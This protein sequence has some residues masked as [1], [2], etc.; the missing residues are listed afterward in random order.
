[1]HAHHFV[2]CFF[3]LVCLC[4]LLSACGAQ[5]VPTTPKVSQRSTTPPFQR[6]HHRTSA[7]RLGQHT[8]R[9]P[10]PTQG[11]HQNIIYIDNEQDTTTV[12]PGV[13]SLKRYDVTTHRQSDIIKLAGDYINEALVSSDGQWLLFVSD[14]GRSPVFKQNCNWCAWMVGIYKRSIAPRRGSR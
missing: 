6:Q 1:M 14:V 2:R 11:S 8:R 9:P 5:T 3:V 7:L 4:L 10:S 13:G 12:A